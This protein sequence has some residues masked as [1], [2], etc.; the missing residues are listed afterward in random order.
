MIALM[1]PCEEMQLGNLLMTTDM[2]LTNS[3]RIFTLACF[4]PCY[5]CSRLYYNN[6]RSFVGADDQLLPPIHDRE[7]N[8]LV[9]NSGNP[10]WIC[11]RCKTSLRKHKLPP[12][13]LVNNMHVPP[14]PLSLAASIAWKRD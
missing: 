10:V 7:L 4:N 5:C 12:F 3:D 11:S 9:Y 14:A 13:A 1:Q 6:G 8:D 2:P